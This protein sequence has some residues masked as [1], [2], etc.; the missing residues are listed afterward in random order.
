M[1]DGP[2]TR[3]LFFRPVLVDMD[4]LLVAGRVGKAIDTI[5]RDLNPFAGSDLGADG[6]FEFTEVAE[7][8]HVG[9]PPNVPF[10]WSDLHFRN[11]RWTEQFI[12]RYLHNFLYGDAGGRLHHG[13]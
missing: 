4:P 13:Y 6:R 8:T 5:L 1:G 12:L 11:A 10:V 7:D 3:Q 9:F 2:A